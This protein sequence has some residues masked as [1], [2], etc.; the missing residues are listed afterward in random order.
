MAGAQRRIDAADQLVALLEDADQVAFRN[1]ADDVLT[2]LKGVIATLGADAA[3][4]PARRAHKALEQRAASLPTEET[5]RSLADKS[6]TL[7]ELARHPPRCPQ[8]G[9]LMLI[10]V[11]EH[12]HFWGCSKFAVEH[13]CGTRSIHL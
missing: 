3:G 11:G 10:Q 1:D 13:C 8:C 7:R 6:K 2:L 4:A 12:G 9:S 5:A